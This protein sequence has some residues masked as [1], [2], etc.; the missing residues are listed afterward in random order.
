M[1][2]V[3]NV[4][5]VDYSRP[6]TSSSNNEPTGT[7]DILGEIVRVRE[8]HTEGMST[9]AFLITIERDCMQ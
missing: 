9:S 4:R 6:P 3:K 2:Y 7:P 5:C 8:L 1:L